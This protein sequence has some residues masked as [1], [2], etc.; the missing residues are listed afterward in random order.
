[1]AACAGATASSAGVGRT[2]GAEQADR[3]KATTK[4][5][6]GRFRFIADM[7]TWR[8]GHGYGTIGTVAGSCYNPA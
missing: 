7:I 6:S 4:S 2:L 8:S 3:A 5:T 1:V